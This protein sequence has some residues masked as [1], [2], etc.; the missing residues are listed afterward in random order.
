MNIRAQINTGFKLDN[1]SNRSKSQNVQKLC[2][3]KSK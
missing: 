1:G 3:T 2:I